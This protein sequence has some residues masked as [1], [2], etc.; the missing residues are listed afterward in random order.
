MLFIPADYPGQLYLRRAVVKRLN[1]IDNTSIPKEILHILSFLGPLHLSLNTRESVF[2][3]FWGFFDSMYR[4]VFGKKKKLAAKPKPWIVNLLLYLAH[5]GWQIV[6]CF[7]MRRFKNSKKTGYLIFLDLLDNLV[8]VTLDVYT[9]L[10]RGNH[11]D[12][13]I[14]AVFR[15]WCIMKRFQR[16]NY[17]K[18]I[19]AFLSDIQYWKQIKHPIM[20]TLKNNLNKLDEYC[21]ENFHSL[22]RRHTNAKVNT[23][24]SLR[25]DALFIDHCKS[26]NNFMSSFAPKKDYPYKKKDLD[27]L[28]KKTAL[29]LLDFFDEISKNDGR[30]EKKMEGKKIKKPYYYILPIKSGFRAGVLPLGYHTKTSPIIEKLCDYDNCKISSTDFQVLICGHS[31]HEECFRVLRLQCNY[32]YSYLSGAI[33]DLTK[34]YNERL[35][36]DEDINNE[37]DLE[38]NLQSEDSDMDAANILN[39]D[40][41]I[42]RSLKERISGN[43]KIY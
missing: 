21:V 39:I 14:S 18:I 19:L 28:I 24:K 17:D 35:N 37:P 36:M 40:G 30:V 29:F 20:D 16:H 12:E 5:G 23:A 9:T 31:Y 3:T 25:R 6:K 10:F 34:S 1:S 8:P 33:D 7:V 22:V 27:E 4:T 15:L 43:Y 2:L 41:E 11:L 13:Y 26:E 42:D 32:C 38:I